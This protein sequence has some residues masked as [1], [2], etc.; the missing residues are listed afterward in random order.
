MSSESMRVSEKFP[1]ASSMSPRLGSLPL[2]RPLHERGID[3]ALGNF[4]L[5][6]IDSLDTLY[7]LGDMEE[8]SRAVRLVSD[9]VAFDT[10]T[11][12]QVFE[13]NIRVLGGLLSAHIL[14]LSEK[15]E[16]QQLSASNHNTVLKSATNRSSSTQTSSSSSTGD[17]RT[18]R[19]FDDYNNEL[20]DL[21]LDLASRLLPAFLESKT[22][23]PYPRVN[24]RYGVTHEP[25]LQQNV[26]CL[27]GVGTLSL[28]SDCC[29]NLVAIRLTNEWP[30]MRYAQFGT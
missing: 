10:D 22:H 14:A 6:L 3:D 18:V 7:V 9:T 27:A 24:L 28:S 15:E 13:A 30:E 19:P 2:T 29:R 21:A 25:H 5:T 8:F 1:K 26:N 23:L 11:N 4:S 17:R 12:V 16:Q 20:Y